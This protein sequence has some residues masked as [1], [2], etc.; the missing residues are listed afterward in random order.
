MAE[1]TPFS[2]ALKA[3]RKEAGLT[4]KTL[5]E[6]SEIPRRTIEDW[7]RGIITPAPYVQK[8]VLEWIKNR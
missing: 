6:V 5:S 2:E 8:L 4:Q 3:A 1:K 7:E